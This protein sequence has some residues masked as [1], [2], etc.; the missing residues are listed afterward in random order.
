M[1]RWRRTSSMEKAVWKLI[2]CP[3]SDGFHINHFLKEEKLDGGMTLKGMVTRA[4]DKWQKM[5][6]EEKQ[7]FVRVPFYPAFGGC[8]AY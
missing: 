1:G 4:R 8:M 5:S 3:A 2:T 7:F 6:P